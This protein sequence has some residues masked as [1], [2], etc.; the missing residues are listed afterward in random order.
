MHR[1]AIQSVIEDKVSFIIDQRP[2][3]FNY[4]C[5]K[6]NRVSYNYTLLLIL[7]LLFIKNRS[8]PAVTCWDIK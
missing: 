4:W 1:I 3:T 5:H 8:F 6:L 7:L 2:E